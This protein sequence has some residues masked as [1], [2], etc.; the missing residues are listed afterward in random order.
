MSMIAERPLIDFP[1][2]NAAPGVAIQVVTSF[3][4]NSARPRRTLFVKNLVLA[5]RRLCRVEVGVIAPV[6]WAPPGWRRGRWA[7]VGSV[8]R[9]E[10]IDG[11]AVQHPRFLAPPRLGVLH[12]LG[13]GLGVLR[14]MRRAALETPGL[15]VHV[16]CAFP[17]GVG[18]ALAARAL[19]LRYVITAHGSDVNVHAAR[20]PLRVQIAWAL[21]N[22]RGVIAVSR[23]LRDQIV[24]LV[25]EI[26]ERTAVIPCAGFDPSVFA[27]RSQARCRA[28]LGLTPGGR[29]VLFVGNL[30]PVK[31]VD[32][33]LRAW[34]RL[35]VRRDPRAAATTLLLVGDGPLRAELER[36]AQALGIA[37]EVRFVG[38]VPQSQV[39]SWIG[40][41]DVLCLPSRSEGM[42]NVVVE[43]LAS[44]VP[45][46]ATGV[47]GVPEVIVDGEN[48]YLERTGE[49][50]AMADALERALSTTW[51]R[52]RIVR[53][54]E[55]MTWMSLAQKNVT[56][57]SEVM[58]ET[59][60][61]HPTAS[62]CMPPTA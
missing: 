21:R 60:P 48:G 10:T 7:G 31:G 47:G 42:P 36:S 40:A 28:D 4:P 25:P 6:P 27:P 1:G 61:C 46:V 8:P 29:I 45:V 52:L 12:G 2:E 9:E 24:G 49:A 56:F 33:L 51:D 11:I 53:T 37:P 18:V 15:V 54:V 14:S 59:I 17:D 35:R 13:F 57:L 55:A 5:M 26:A 50:D 23:A 34:A 30:V 39:A 62:T 22:A 16:H 32:L 44:A 41:A 58:K 43:S 38:S 20:G 3:F 19:G